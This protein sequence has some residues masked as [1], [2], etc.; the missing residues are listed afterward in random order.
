MG[1]EIIET[2]D[3]DSFKGYLQEYENTICG[4][5]PISVFLHVSFFSSLY[6]MELFHLCLFASEHIQV[7]NFCSLKMTQ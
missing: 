7:L 1:M 5:H 4:R 6:Y 2:G 3:P